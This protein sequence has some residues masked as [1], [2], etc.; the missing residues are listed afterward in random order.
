MKCLPALTLVMLMMLYSCAIAGADTSEQI[1]RYSVQDTNPQPGAGVIKIAGCF[2][3]T[4]NQSS[5]DTPAMKGAMLAAK[6]IN[7][8]GGVLGGSLD[9]VIRDSYYNQT[10]AE[11]NARTLI[12]EDKVVSGIGFSDTDSVLA[13]GPVFQESGI[14]F[15]AVGASSPKIPDQVGDMIYLACFGDNVQAAAGAEYA[16]RSFGNSSYL[17]F[18]RS[19]E[20]TV[21]LA[22]YF[23]KSFSELGGRVVLEDSYSNDEGNISEQISRLKGLHNQPDFYYIAAM[24]NNVGSVVWQFRQAGLGGPIVGGDGYDTPDLVSTAG[25]AS[26]DVYFSTHCLMDSENGNEGIRRFIAAYNKEYGYNPENAFAALGYDAL[27]LMADAIGRAGSTDPEA[28]SEAIQETRNFPGITGNISY[29]NG[30]HVP[31]KGV[32]IIAVKD[33]S[34]TLA[35]EFVPKAVPAP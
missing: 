16:A 13:A 19:N 11:E 25:N 2:A 17:L 10:K 30:T 15:I 22:G 33:E 24:P 26:N 4:G 12:E 28:I 31:Q 23:K 34:F 29:L 18:D 35:D 14:P 9:L 20:Y 32:T 8:S 21:L 27:R 3:I 5:L 1:V 6:E 7:A